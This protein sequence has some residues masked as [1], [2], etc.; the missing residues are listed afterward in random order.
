M[1][2]T[3][4]YHRLTD[5]FIQVI[6][7]VGHDVVSVILYGSLVKGT[8]RPGMSDLIDAVVIFKQSLLACPED[9]YRMLDT[10]TSICS[11]IS[12]TGV[13]FHPFHY[14]FLDHS[15]WSTVAL[16]FPAWTSS[17]YSKVVAGVDARSLLRTTDRNLEF[18]R[19]WYFAA[20]RSL[21]RRCFLMMSDLHLPER[22]RQVVAFAR[23][24]VKDLPQFA[25][26]AC[27]LLVDRA[28]AMSE[29]VQ[30]FPDCDVN[31]L[32]ALSQEA[33]ESLPEVDIEKARKLLN[34]TVDLSEKLY[35]AVVAWLGN[36]SG[37]PG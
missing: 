24:F 20:H 30:F 14:F 29:M 6:S 9:Y 25:C 35:Q 26:L 8:V 32:R 36:S 16:Y 22:R 23:S 2:D 15:E 3:S 31:L 21:L 28:D 11:R 4:D 19:G 34:Q 18:M 7:S 27:G 12:Q 33:N 17:R 37:L 13:T 1:I 5:E 10:A